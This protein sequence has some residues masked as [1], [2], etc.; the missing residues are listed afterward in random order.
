MVV[1][2][3]EKQVVASRLAR[4]T[5]IENICWIVLGVL[6]VLSVWGILAGIWNIIGGIVGFETEK[7]ILR[8][9][10]K[11]PKEAKKYWD[12][13]LFGIINVFVGGVV[14]VAILVYWC[15]NRQE[16]LKN[17][18]IFDD[19]GT[20]SYCGGS[21]LPTAF[22]HSFKP[23]GDVVQKLEKCAE[24]YKKGILTKAEFEEQKKM[25]LNNGL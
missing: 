18:D 14:G 2:D 24:L 12:I 6:Q 7:Q 25:L 21:V 9:E 1:T 3:S 19:K 10:K 11:V 8:R 22:V 15:W 16:I 4:C 17:K 5:R 23:E 13:V 20:G